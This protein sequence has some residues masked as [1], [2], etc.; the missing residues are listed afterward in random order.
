M[1]LIFLCIAFFYKKI[2]SVDTTFIYMSY[3]F[4][5]VSAL[6]IYCAL[7]FFSFVLVAKGDSTIEDQVVFENIT[8]ISSIV[9]AILYTIAFCINNNAKTS[10]RNTGDRQYYLND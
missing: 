8:R 3:Q 5:L 2:Q 7:T 1:I 10:L 4:W 6:L 9:K